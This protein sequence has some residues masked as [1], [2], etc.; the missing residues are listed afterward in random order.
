MCRYIE[1]MKDIHKNSSVTVH[2]HKESGDPDRSKTGGHHITESVHS[3][4]A[5]HNVEY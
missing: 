3:N 5:D 1:N 2:L 4:T